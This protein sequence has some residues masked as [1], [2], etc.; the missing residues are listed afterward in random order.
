MKGTSLRTGLEIE[1]EPFI[2]DLN[3]PCSTTPSSPTSETDE[4]VP[5]KDFSSNVSDL[6]SAS[7]L[8]SDLGKCD[9][10]SKTTTTSSI[11]DSKSGESDLGYNTDSTDLP[12]LHPLPTSP[13]LTLFETL[14]SDLRSREPSP[15]SRAA[16]LYYLPRSPVVQRDISAL[17]PSL[18]DDTEIMSYLATNIGYY[19]AHNYISDTE[20]EYLLAQ[21]LVCGD[22][23]GRVYQNL[24]NRVLQLYHFTKR[25]IEQYR[26]MVIPV[27][28]LREVENHQKM[29]RKNSR[30]HEK[31]WRRKRAAARCTLPEEWHARANIPLPYGCSTYADVFTD[32]NESYTLQGPPCVDW[33]QARPSSYQSLGLESRR[34][35]VAVPDGNA[36]KRVPGTTGLVAATCEAEEFSVTRVSFEAL[37]SW[38]DESGDGVV[39]VLPRFAALSL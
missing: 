19:Y 35:R 29:L 27:H 22:E 34:P 2:L 36:D 9:L 37:G 32:V 5:S 21:I 10:F 3:S 6:A 33:A 1:I 7:C 14:A 31:D 17:V 39:I 16:I 30:R 26:N 12:A 11:S 4:S 13:S 18:L 38:S 24:D 28:K 20:L 15:A 25:Q 8:T 23:Q